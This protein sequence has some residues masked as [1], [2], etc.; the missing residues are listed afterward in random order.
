MLLMA[1]RLVLAENRIQSLN[2]E[3]SMSACNTSN[4]LY[5]GE[6]ADRLTLRL[7]FVRKYSLI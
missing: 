4:D 3:S 2:N 5:L 1:N 7:N 6:R